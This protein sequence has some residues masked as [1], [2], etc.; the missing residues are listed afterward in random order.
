MLD[1]IKD[2]QID[3][4]A[5]DVEWADQAEL[6]MRYGKHW[7][8][9][10]QKLT[11]AEENIKIIRAELIKQANENPD[12]FLGEG[13]KPTAPNIESYYRNHKKHKEAKTAWIEA[14]Y[15]LNMATIAKNEISFTRKAALEA[16]VTL[17]GQQYFAGPSAPRNLSEE[18][19]KREK[20]VDAGIARKL[21]APERTRTRI[22]TS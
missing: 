5:L 14:Q 9:C 18:Y 3:V 12:K 4:D 11:E 17:H 19:K 10:Q 22:R 16:L 20:K 8:T 2:S 15:T 21:A 1:Y 7:A 6:A 13:V